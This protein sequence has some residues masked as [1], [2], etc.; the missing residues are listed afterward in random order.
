MT[1]REIG[2]VVLGCSILR[3]IVEE[4]RLWKLD[5][6]ITSC[7]EKKENFLV[8]DLFIPVQWVTK[9]RA[10]QASKRAGIEVMAE[11]LQVVESWVEAH[12]V[13]V[14]DIA[15]EYQFLNRYTS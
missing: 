6:N 7:D 9:V 1:G 13:L 10:T 4:E 14:K 11:C 5:R 15:P 3:M 12:Q 2:F 8:R